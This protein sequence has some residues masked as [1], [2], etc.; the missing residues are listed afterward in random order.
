MSKASRRRQPPKP[1]VEREADY[2][3]L[4]TKA[5]QEL[6]EANEENSPE[7]SPQELRKYQG[8]HLKV[9]DWVKMLLF[10]FWFA[11]A[12]CFF[13]LWGLGGYFADM[14]DTLFVTAIAYGI[15]TD[16]LTNNVLRYFEKTKGAADRFIM[17]TKRGFLSFPLNIL[18]AFVVIVLVFLLYNGVN[19]VLVSIS[20]NKDSV[21][22]PVEPICFG[23]FCL[24]A[25][26]LLIE[27]KRL[28]LRLFR[29]GSAA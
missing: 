16:L 7:V 1:E 20:G 9:S 24:A 2:Y 28:I 27:I 13:F 23:L 5:V 22:L 29:R 21:P 15:V 10:K 8:R 19:L 4:N 14:L 26:M 11:G 3:K 18:Y 17:V 6:V 12:V 25:D